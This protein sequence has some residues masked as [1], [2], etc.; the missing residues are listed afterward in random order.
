[1]EENG[2]GEEGERKDGT[3][4]SPL[5]GLDSKM[6]RTNPFQRAFWVTST[7]IKDNLASRRFY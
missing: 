3:K 6:E 7:N 2:R 1:M 4:F 5:R